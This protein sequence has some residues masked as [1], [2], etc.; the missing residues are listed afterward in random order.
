MT[1]HTDTF[2]LAASHCTVP[3]PV[4]HPS[5]GLVFHVPVHTHLCLYI[6]SVLYI[7]C[8]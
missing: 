8:E 1:Q 2:F 5:F 3:V 7:V 4:Q 6:G